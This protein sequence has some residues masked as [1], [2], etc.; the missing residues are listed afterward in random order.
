MTST[1]LE[2]LKFEISNV[3]GRFMFYGL[4]TGARGLKPKQR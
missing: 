2:R 3:L 1:K 4:M